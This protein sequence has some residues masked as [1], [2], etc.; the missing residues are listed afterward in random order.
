MSDSSP[1]GET[2]AT[3]GKT[4][5]IEHALGYLSTLFYQI[6]ELFFQEGLREAC[7]RESRSLVFGIEWTIQDTEIETA[8]AESHT[9]P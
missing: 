8:T 7:C 2:G 4:K 3:I 5:E 9:K 1:W 6:L